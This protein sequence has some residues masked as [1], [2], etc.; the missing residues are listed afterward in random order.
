MLLEGGHAPIGIEAAKDLEAGKREATK[1]PALT[2]PRTSDD[3]SSS[4]MTG[5]RAR[6]VPGQRWGWKSAVHGHARARVRAAPHPLTPP[7]LT[8]APLPRA[9]DG[10]ST[11]PLPLDPPAYECPTKAHAHDEPAKPTSTWGKFCAWFK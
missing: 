10:V 6:A 2:H 4:A 9:A 7:P 1:L 11:P 3:S 5:E 8:P